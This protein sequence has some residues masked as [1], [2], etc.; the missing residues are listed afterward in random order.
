[1]LRGHL[2]MGLL[3]R[4]LVFA[5]LV[6]SVAVAPA[7]GNAVPNLVRSQVDVAIA[8]VRP[9]LVRIRVVVNPDGKPETAT[10]WITSHKVGFSGVAS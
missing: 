9:A 10:E 3:A 8:K 6:T 5:F 4:A 1:M 7:K 2:F